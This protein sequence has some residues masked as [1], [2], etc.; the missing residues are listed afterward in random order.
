MVPV[1]SGSFCML[2]EKPGSELAITFL[3]YKILTSWRCEEGEKR[4][5]FLRS[6]SPGRAGSKAWV[7]G[8]ELINVLL[9]CS[10]LSGK[11]WED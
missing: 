9:Q 6:L 5:Q 1:D 2:R 7:D 4:Q 10:Y 11:N 3:H 8:S